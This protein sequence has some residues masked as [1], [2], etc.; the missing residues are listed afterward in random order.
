MFAANAATRAR[1]EMAVKTAQIE[2][3]GPGNRDVDPV[4]LRNRHFRDLAFIPQNPFRE[5]KPGRKLFIVAGRP[6]GYRDVPPV[7][8]DFERFFHRNRILLLKRHPFLYAQ[9]RRADRAFA[10]D[11]P[12]I[13]RRETAGRTE[14]VMLQRHRKV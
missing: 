4:F 14:C 6:H 1:V 2:S 13:I 5:K 11:N 3:G 12:R 10:H 8:G 9:N 7:D